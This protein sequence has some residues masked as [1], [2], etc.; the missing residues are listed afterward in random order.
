MTRSR[1][2]PG[3]VTLSISVLI[4][5]YRHPLLTAPMSAA[6]QFKAATDLVWYRS[7]I[8]LWI[9]G[10]SSAVPSTRTGTERRVAGLQ[11]EGE[12]RAVMDDTDDRRC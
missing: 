11:C 10:T 8:P 2:R 4:V 3:G 12:G 9:G 1:G 6:V 5:L 7:G